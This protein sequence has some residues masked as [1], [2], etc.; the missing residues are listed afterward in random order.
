MCV[1]CTVYNRAV[2]YYFINC[3]VVFGLGAVL[4]SPWGHPA[5]WLTARGVIAEL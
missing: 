4:A 2:L 1:H 3:I 5:P